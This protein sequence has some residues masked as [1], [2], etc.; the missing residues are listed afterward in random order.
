MPDAPIVLAQRAHA[1]VWAGQLLSE[2]VEKGRSGLSP[3]SKVYADWALA[4]FSWWTQAENPH[5]PSW[6]MF[7]VQAAALL[8]L[9]PSAVAPAKSSG[10]IVQWWIE[11]LSLQV[12]DPRIDA[13]GSGLAG[14]GIMLSKMRPISRCY[15][16]TETLS[17]I[18]G[19]GRYGAVASV[20][21]LALRFPK[22]PGAAELV[23]LTS[24]YL[25]VLATLLALSAKP[26]TDPAYKG[27]AGMWYTGPTV[28]PVGERSE[29]SGLQND[30]GGILEIL[31]GAKA[32]S[33]KRAGWPAVVFA[34]L[35]AE[36]PAAR[37]EPRF[38]EEILSAATA[39]DALVY[40]LNNVRLW[41]E[42]HWT[43]FADG[44]LVWSPRRLNTNTAKIFWAWLD[45]KAQKMTIGFPWPQG[46]NRETAGAGN[47]RLIKEVDGWF[48]CADGVN[49]GIASTLTISGAPLWSIVGDPA[50]FR[51]EALGG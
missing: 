14:T 12:G 40:P 21:L 27:G 44:L 7:V 9:N 48:L 18:Y 31:R 43:R 22:A 37:T 36:F 24:R 8:W 51:M 33:S 20:R 16:G 42:Q 49:G 23:R 2:L 5:Q 45:D 4:D 41:S 19:P 34:K 47:C 30:L 50:G 26:W 35:A 17:P 29:A 15:D 38:A 11:W 25:E 1:E 3:E 32:S 10:S 46:R 28:S 13:P 39:A 6:N